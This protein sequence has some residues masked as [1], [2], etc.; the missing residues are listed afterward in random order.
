MNVLS[1]SHELL[2]LPSSVPLRNSN[3]IIIIII[4]GLSALADKVIWSCL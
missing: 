1:I 4:K 2:T 3:L